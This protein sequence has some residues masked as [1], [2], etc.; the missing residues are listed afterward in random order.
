MS[1]YGKN[2]HVLAALF[3]RLL[4]DKTYRT[5]AHAVLVHVPGEENGCTVRRK[6][7]KP[8]V[9]LVTVAATCA[10]NRGPQQRG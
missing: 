7:S 2:P 8:Q 4:F 10:L 3:Q 1:T 5:A 6:P 9:L